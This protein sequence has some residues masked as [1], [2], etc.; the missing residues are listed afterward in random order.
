M[1]R[2]KSLIKNIQITE[3]KRTHSCK[4]NNKHKIL[5]GNLRIT[6]KEGQNERNYCIDCGK[7]FIELA[8][9]ELD[10]LRKKCEKC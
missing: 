8:I 10:E 1:G 2:P 5:K 9:N 4:S 6:V 3:A 7:R